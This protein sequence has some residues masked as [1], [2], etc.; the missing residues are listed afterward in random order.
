MLCP[1]ITPNFFRLCRCTNGEGGPPRRNAN[2]NP[3]VG[4]HCV[5]S[6]L[7]TPN[8]QPTHFQQITHSGGWGGYPCRPLRIDRRHEFNPCVFMPLCNTP[9]PIAFVFKG[10]R[11]YG[12]EGGVLVHLQRESVQILLAGKEGTWCKATALLHHPNASSYVRKSTSS[13]WNRC[14]AV[15]SA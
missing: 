9:P 7:H 14:T 4:S 11:Y 6:R 13:R 12:R 2:V 15:A 3:L 8:L 1:E 5:F 10:L